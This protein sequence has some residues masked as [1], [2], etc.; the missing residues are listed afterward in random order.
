MLR[1]INNLGLALGDAWRALRDYLGADRWKRAEPIA[2][3][4]ALRHFLES[5]A[6]YVTQTS[7]YGYLR[8]RA[9][10]RYPQLFANDEF[11]RAI[12]IAKWQM[13]LACLSDLSVYAGGLIARRSGAGRSRIT[14]L[15]KATIDAILA[16][17]EGS[18]DGERAKKLRARIA[19][20]DWAAVPDDATP[21]SESPRT[22]VECAPIV[23]EL[24]Q[25]DEEIVRNSVR[26]R[27]QEVRRDLRR[28][29]DA[30]ALMASDLEQT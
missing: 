20:A 9:G 15:M 25:L 1:R 6:S 10:M 8:T 17:S 14:S 12:D 3:R 5:R 16:E 18:R 4:D 11:V 2:D 30:E 21:F 27:W 29:L 26:F 28:D 24:K 13:W 22:L 23:E 19:G 7:L